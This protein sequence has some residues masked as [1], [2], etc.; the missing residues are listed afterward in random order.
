[1]NLR[2]SLPEGMHAEVS[3]PAYQWVEELSEVSPERQDAFVIH[4][5][6]WSK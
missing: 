6:T 2:L 5:F 1:M 3:S 4:R